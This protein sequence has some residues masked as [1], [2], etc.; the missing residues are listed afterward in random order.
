MKSIMFV[1]MAFVMGLTT[2]ACKETKAADEQQ[3]TTETATAAVSDSL[4]KVKEM[5]ISSVDSYSTAIT[6]RI[7]QVEKRMATAT[8]AGKEKLATYLADLKKGLQD[9]QAISAKLAG[10][11]AD[12][13]AAE[14]EASMPALQDIKYLLSGEGLGP[15]GN[16]SGSAT[17]QK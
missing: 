8:G 7:E 1:F 3:T 10:A 11:S 5:I 2:F 13:W 17:L 15:D 6:S 9:A 12:T 4:A 16:V 14:Y